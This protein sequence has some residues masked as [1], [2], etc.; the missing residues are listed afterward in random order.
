MSQDHREQEEMKR[1]SVSTPA[2]KRAAVDLDG[3]YRK[4]GI[5]AVAAA[6]P[7]HGAAEKPADAP[8]TPCDEGW[9]RRLMEAA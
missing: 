6:L 4:I 1:N 9:R 7:Y 2:V 8:G 3:Q 5:S